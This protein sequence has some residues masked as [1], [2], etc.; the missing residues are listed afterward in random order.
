MILPCTFFRLRLALPPRCSHLVKK[1]VLV[2]IDLDSIA[3]DV[4]FALDSIDVQDCWGRAGGSRDGY[5]SP[6]QAAADLIDEEL[7]PF[8]DQARRYHAMEMPAEEA[9]YRRGVILGIYRYEQEAKSEFRELAVDIPIDC[10]G[11]LLD[12]WR[13]RG[14]DSVTTAAMDAFIRKRCPNWASDLI[15]TGRRK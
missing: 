12:E 14:Q 1:A 8:F 6:D 15:R 5:N 9:A 4:Y 7:Q 10:A 11:A 13:K 3:D 2:E